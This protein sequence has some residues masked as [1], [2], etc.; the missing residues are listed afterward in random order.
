MQSGW[1]LI[2]AAVLHVLPLQ[3]SPAAAFDYT[4]P[5]TNITATLAGTIV[6][7]QV[8][9]PAQASLKT[10]SIT[11]VSPTTIL[12]NNGVVAFN[13]GAS[14]YYAIYDPTRTNWFSGSISSG[15]T[16]DLRNG[17][18]VV[19]WSSG[20]TV[21]Y[22]VYDPTRGGWRAG[23]TVMSASAGTDLRTTNGVVSWSSGNTVYFTV[24]DPALGQ[25]Q[26]GSRA[27]AATTSNLT[28]AHGVVV[29]SSSTIISARTY[30]PNRR[31][32]AAL[33]SSPLGSPSDLKTG[34]GVVAWS[35]G[36]T[37]YYEVYDSSRSNWVTGSQPFSG[38]TVGV[39]V[40]SGTVS[41]STSTSQSYTR[42]Y[43]NGVWY[44]GV[45]LPSAAFFISTNF[46]NPPLTVYFVDMSI[47]ANAWNWSF[48]DGGS[49]IQRSPLYTF[50][51]FNRYN[52]TLTASG[53][54][55]ANSISKEIVSDI[56]PPA[57]TIKINGTN[58]FVTS[59]QVTLS[60]S[61]SDNSGVV[62]AM[63]F[64]N[65]NGPFSNWEPYATNKAWVLSAGDG[66]KTVN[67][68]FR[69]IVENVSATA[70]DTITLDT[71]PPSNVYFAF[72]NTNL[73]ESII[74]YQVRVILDPPFPREVSVDFSTSDGTANAGPDYTPT[75]GRLVF[76]PGE[77]VKGFPLTIKNDTEV[78]LNETILL[79]LSNPTNAVVGPQATVTIMDDDPPAIAF[80]QANFSVDESAGG[81]IITVGLSAASG[82]TVSVGYAVSNGTATAG[83]DYSAVGGTLVFS[84]GQISRSFTVPIL[85]DTADETN[86]TV[87]L[88]LRN[89][90]NGVFAT[91]P[92]SVLTIMDDD[93]PTV[94]FATNFY[95]VN[96]SSG[97]AVVTVTLSKPF[98][99]TVFVDIST[100]GGTAQ[101]GSDYVSA[102]TTLIFAPQQTLKT[103]Q[104]T[105]LNDSAYESNKTFG[106]FL[107]NFFN[108]TPGVINANVQIQD[109]DGI[110]LS[111]VNTNG[112]LKIVLTGPAGQRCSLESSSFLSNWSSVA[113]IT[114]FTGTTTYDAGAPTGSAR[115]YRALLLP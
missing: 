24:Y 67:V 23:S 50:R 14:V 91:S 78:E 86:E 15:S 2:L 110:R 53:I 108:C 84:P 31:L 75:S 20:N 94:R 83:V 5:L 3:Q 47:G 62:T 60:L 76:G 13:S 58:T 69:D 29:W 85:N 22:R 97:N 113:T 89:P 103:F 36:S 45:T 33:D 115:F 96:E 55:G 32:W 107:S 90:T 57:G 38:T 104:I 68:Q 105:I 99:Q 81:A 8:F 61:A 114:N 70:S 100:G 112:S 56:S 16:F 88:W 95:S 72:T 59:N 19:A 17:H 54:G 71:T 26:T 44:A 64:S 7:L 101:P 10:G 102:S 27:N 66:V 39:G 34:D 43:S 80:G 1:W 37:A 9:D 12:T 63:R 52:V 30:D 21:Y 93:P 98:S 65:E 106:V 4:P 111:A 77:V 40:N 25:W 48:G 82:Q 18:G 74:T 42:G 109:D 73:N 6:S 46:S 92:T 87:L 11:G 35:I 49:S 41:W 79:T 51:G 28:N